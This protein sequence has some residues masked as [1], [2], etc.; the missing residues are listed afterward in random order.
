MRSTE[1]APSAFLVNGAPVKRTTKEGLASVDRL[2]GW[3]EA[4]VGAAY[5]K[6]EFLTNKRMA[7]VSA[8]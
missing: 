2:A 7:A 4:R 5:R 8:D 3:F 1:R 6:A